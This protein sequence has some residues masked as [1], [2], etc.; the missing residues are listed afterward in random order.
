MMAGPS[1]SLRMSS[2][3]E[4][5]E[6]VESKLTYGHT[7]GAELARDNA[8]LIDRCDRRD[9]ADEQRAERDDEIEPKRPIVPHAR[10]SSSSPTPALRMAA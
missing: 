8:R 6:L 9:G 5:G 1:P 2:S 7:V 4:Y 10:T 3:V